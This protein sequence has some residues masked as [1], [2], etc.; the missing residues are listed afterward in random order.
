MP[1]AEEC[2]RPFYVEPSVLLKA[3]FAPS[4]V[5]ASNAIN[6]LV[7]GTLLVS[8][9]C[10]IA[11]SMYG[12]SVFIFGLVVITALYGPSLYATLLNGVAEGFGTTCS[13][14]TKGRKA[15]EGFVQ[16]DLTKRRKAT[17]G[18]GTTC[19]RKATEGFLVQK[20]LTKG[21]KATEGFGTTCSPSTKRNTVA[22]GF[23][24]TTADNTDIIGSAIAVTKPTARNPF[25]NILVD[26]LKYN[27]NRA[28]AEDVN[29]PLVKTQ[30]DDFFRVQWSSD[31]TDVFGKSQSQRQ[32]YT[33]PSTSIP[34]D[35]GSY[36]NWLYKIP[37]KT[38]KEGGREAC[39]AQNNSPLVSNWVGS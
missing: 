35:Q 19:S 20:D 25:M 4:L 17:E 30:L 10:L 32:F 5:C 18:F 28:S 29:D 3:Q 23:A 22:E 1:Y 14:S 6:S 9:L 21:R 26:E 33:M 15:T 36:Q 8:A 31:P 37:G 12:I 11:S 24:T 39:V 2:E 16:K 34:N 7:R 13:P 38:C 27:P